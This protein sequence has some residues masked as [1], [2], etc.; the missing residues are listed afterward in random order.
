MKI[1]VIGSGCATC[2]KLH[3]ITQK[4]VDEMGINEK[5]EYLIGAE[6]TQAIIEMGMMQSPVLTVNGE[7]VMTGFTSDREKI[8]KVIASGIKSTEKTPKCSCG[9]KC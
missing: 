2:K 4:A 7:P 9:G 1:Q 8:K 5:V 6:G 3:E